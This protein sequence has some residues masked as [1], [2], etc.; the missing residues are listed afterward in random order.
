MQ[1]PRSTHLSILGKRTRRGELLS[2]SNCQQLQT[3]DTTPNP[4]RPKTTITILDGDD[5]K[6]NIPPYLIRAVNG[7]SSSPISARAARAL[8]RTSTEAGITSPRR[9]PLPQRRASTSSLIPP[10]TPTTAVGQLTISTPPPTPPSLLPIHTRARTLLRP[11]SDCTGEMPGREKERSVIRNFITIFDNGDQITNLYI[12]GSPGTGKTVLV[13]A[14]I[15]SLGSDLNGTKI[16]TV[17]CMALKNVEAL[18][19]RLSEEFQGPCKRKQS[20]STAKG[21]GKEAVEDILSSLDSK[22]YS[23]FLYLSRA[24]THICYSL[25]VLDEL[26]HI[27][28]TTQSLSAVFSLPACKSSALRIIGIA[29]THTLTSSTASFSSSVQTLH[30][31]PYTPAQLQ[32]IVQAR[33]APLYNSESAEEAK[34]FLPT[35]TLILL[36]KK[37]AALTGDVRSLFEVLRGAIDAAASASISKDS[38]TSSKVSAHAPS[39]KM[40]PSVSSS[41][42]SSCSDIASKVK[43]LGLQARLVLLSILLSSKRM[44]AGLPLT[45]STP[46]SP[47]KRSQSS[48]RLSVVATSMETSQLH[49][50]YSAVLRRGDNDVFVPVSR[51]EFGDIT[52]MLEGFGL[53]ST[54]SVLGSKGNKRKLTRTAS[55]TQGAQKNVVSGNVQLASGVWPEEILRGMGIGASETSVSEDVMEEEVSALWR[56]ELIRL[57]RDKK[58]AGA[59][60]QRDPHF[61]SAMED[62]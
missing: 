55:F 13:N 49:V 35:A 39:N 41:N 52:G 24:V 40:S 11:T 21:K 38:Q 23:S 51:S 6:E 15:Q 28:T 48:S 59:K 26:D 56:Q 18:W 29:N 16:I 9:Q 62:D 10:S 30:F 60:V 27:A 32:L 25:L 31:P 37:V 54:T 1:T 12:S 8:R 58:N 46:P 42:T 50:F 14:L 33:L 61:A 20:R 45:M 57:E 19:E 7:D 17:N 4:K 2:P 3:P 53:V 47:M 43:S 5:N 34:K 36:T 44:E 22:W